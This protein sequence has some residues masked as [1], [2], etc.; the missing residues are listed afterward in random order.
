MQ[1]GHGRLSGGGHRRRRFGLSRRGRRKGLSKGEAIRA[2]VLQDFRGVGEP[3]DLERNVST[4]GDLLAGILKDLRL[5]EGIEESRL[6]EAWFEV[7]GEF[8]AKQTEP[9]SLR[10]GVLTLRVL[11]PSMR[12]HLEQSRGNLLKRLKANLGPE[13]IRDVR[14]TIG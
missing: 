5:N 10:Q 4:P 9:V 7:A 1:G 3:L 2:R 12:F 8:V 13:T 14:L 11:Q 6:R